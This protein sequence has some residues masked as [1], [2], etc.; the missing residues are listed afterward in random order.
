[1][2]KVLLII[3]IILVPVF[4]A[5]SVAA[6]GFGLIT[7]PNQCRDD[8]G[9]LEPCPPEYMVTLESAGSFYTANTT[10]SFALLL[11][12]TYCNCQ[13]SPKSVALPITI[14]KVVLSGVGRNWT[15]SGWNTFAT[16]P[17]ETCV[18]N[19][20]PLSAIGTSTAESCA[21]SGITFVQANSTSTA[22]QP[23][24]VL[25]YTFSFSDGQ[26]YS[27]AVESQ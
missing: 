20:V 21:I 15:G 2:K 14:S 9:D 12:K 18:G 23:Y 10:F 3:V 13:G 1:M 16:I 24:Y 7:L 5:A 26:T 8:I 11:D 22:P 6:Y 25:T 4:L 17:N 19:F 27:G